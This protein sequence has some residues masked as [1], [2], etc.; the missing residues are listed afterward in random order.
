MCGYFNQVVLQCA[1]FNLF[2]HCQYLARHA[3]VSFK[4]GN[5]ITDVFAR[6]YSE[7]ISENRCHYIQKCVWGAAHVSQGNSQTTCSQMHKLGGSGNMKPLK[8]S[9]TGIDSE[10]MFGLKYYLNFNL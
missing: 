9:I 6:A 2:S 10:A 3:G 8:N 1:C 7:I 5:T 4:D